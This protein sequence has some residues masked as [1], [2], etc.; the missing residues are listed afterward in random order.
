MLESGGGGN[1]RWMGKGGGREGSFGLYR[2][3]E[4]GGEPQG[5]SGRH[6]VEKRLRTRARHEGRE[7]TTTTILAR[8]RRERKGG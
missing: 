6:G 4:K 1:I 2:P 5:C 8:G 3:G 7:T